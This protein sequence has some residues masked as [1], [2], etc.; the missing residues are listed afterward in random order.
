M[1]ETPEPSRR[2]LWM[3]QTPSPRSSCC[4][5]L[6]EGSTLSHQTKNSELVLVLEQVSE[7][8][9]EDE[10]FHGNHDL[11]TPV[12][13]NP[14]PLPTLDGFSGRKTSPFFP[15]CNTNLR[16]GTS[17]P[18]KLSTAPPLPSSPDLS[19]GGEFRMIP[20][21]FSPLG[22]SHTIDI[23]PLLQRRMELDDQ[24]EDEMMLSPESFPP[25][26]PPP[27]PQMDSLPPPMP[28]FETPEQGPRKKIGLNRA[29]QMRKGPFSFQ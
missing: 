22:T 18:S 6:G 17:T 24:D 21:H 28:W 13:L 11:R 3:Y 19:A 4:S 9:M 8:T 5:D 16:G 25:S 26:A 29:L 1:T 12:S 27:T 2:P 10:A 14:R 7:L 15:C 23:G 20:P